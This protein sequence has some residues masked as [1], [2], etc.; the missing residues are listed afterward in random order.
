MLDSTR[1][2]RL[3]CPALIALSVGCAHT[4][5][6]T[7]L[8]PLGQSWGDAP[9][10]TPDVR[11]LGLDRDGEVVIQPEEADRLTCRYRRDLDDE[12]AIAIDYTKVCYLDGALFELTVTPRPGFESLLASELAAFASR[13]TEYSV[14]PDHRIVLRDRAIMDDIRAELRGQSR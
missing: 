6:P 9:P 10:E 4:H 7:P 12:M 3:I 14:T 11:T 8:T 1:L 13:S 5:G 2:A